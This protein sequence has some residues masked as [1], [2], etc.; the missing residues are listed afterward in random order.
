MLHVKCAEGSVTKSR[1]PGGGSEERCRQAPKAAEA[2]ICG[3]DA[4]AGEV[5]RKAVA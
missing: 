1:V 4:S 2:A 3:V 5:S